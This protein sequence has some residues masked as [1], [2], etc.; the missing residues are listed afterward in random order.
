MKKSLRVLFVIA[1]ILALQGIVFFVG[2]GLFYHT[3][4]FAEEISPDTEPPSI[5]D[6]LRYTEVTSNAAEIT[7]DDST[8]NVGVTGYEIYIKGKSR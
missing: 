8:D 5:P 2:H 7:W 1:I 3:A 6:N 4:V